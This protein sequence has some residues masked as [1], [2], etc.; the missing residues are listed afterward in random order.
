[1]KYEIIGTGSSGNC[2]ILDDI[3]LDCGLPYKQIKPYL[4]DIKL[5]FISHKHSDHLNKS[6][7]KK[8]AYNNP[9][10]KFL[11]AFYLVDLLLELGVSK[12]NIITVDL[13]KWYN[14]G[15]ANVKLE[16][17]MHDVPNT[18]L[19]IQKGNQKAIY[20]VDTNSVDHL[21]AKDYNLYMI[22][23][24]YT[25]EEEL[26]NR[27]KKDYEEGL[28]YSHYERVRKTHL[29]QLKAYNWLQKNMNEESEF[30]FLHAHRDKEREE[31]GNEK[32][33]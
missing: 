24:N 21:V 9:T 32:G 33:N 31:K 29:S 30:V 2:V 19:K 14:I 23:A 5:I 16:A 15:I 17:L 6:T 11:V 1:M 12:K 7:I 3:M 18:A 25:D 22:E 27:I 20:I 8:I 28:S 4:K 26:E 13:E 10:I